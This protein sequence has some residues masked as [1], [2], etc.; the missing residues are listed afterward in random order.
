MF[1]GVE[2]SMV[3]VLQGTGQDY[4]VYS[5]PKRPHDFSTSAQMSV[6]VNI[7]C[8]MKSSLELNYVDT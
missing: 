7:L 5:V 6:Q 3:D 1:S 2:A 8:V 4:P